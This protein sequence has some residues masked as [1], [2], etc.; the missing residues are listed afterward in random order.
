MTCWCSRCQRGLLKWAAKRLWGK[1]FHFLLIHFSHSGAAL[2]LTTLKTHFPPERKMGCVQLP[3]PQLSRWFTFHVALPCSSLSTVTTQST[4]LDPSHVFIHSHSIVFTQP[5]R[6]QSQLF[7]SFLGGG[8]EPWKGWLSEYTNQ[9]FIVHPQ[10]QWNS[11]RW[12]I[13]QK[14]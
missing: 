3:T 8:G 10:I 4:C 13:I 12:I 9:T 14:A 6:P 1:D 2:L 11:L 5:L 7:F